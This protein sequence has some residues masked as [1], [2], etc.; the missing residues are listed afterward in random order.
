MALTPVDSFQLASI[1][2]GG[3]AVRNST[4]GIYSYVDGGTIGPAT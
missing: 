1:K 2:Y 3:Y 4:T